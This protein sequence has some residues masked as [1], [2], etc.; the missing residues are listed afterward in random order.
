MATPYGSYHGNLISRREVQPAARLQLQLAASVIDRLIH[1]NDGR[2]L[3]DV[4]WDDESLDLLSDTELDLDF[5]DPE[6]ETLPE[7]DEIRHNIFECD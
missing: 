4:F 2:D 5:G 6:E 3:A 1:A 7:M